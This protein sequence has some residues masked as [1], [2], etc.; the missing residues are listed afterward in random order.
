M[1]S[2]N[3]L[4]LYFEITDY[5]I[6]DSVTVKTRPHFKTFKVLKYQQICNVA[7]QKNKQT[8][9][10]FGTYMTQEHPDCCMLRTDR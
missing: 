4:C 8:K 2:Y 9:K 7:C 10:T 5:L 1:I 6:I 3:I